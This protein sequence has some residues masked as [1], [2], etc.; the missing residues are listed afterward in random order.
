MTNQE[1]TKVKIERKYHYFKVPKNFGN[2]APSLNFL[3]KYSSNRNPIQI[4]ENVSRGIYRVDKISP[5]RVEWHSNSKLI[6]MK[7][8]KSI[9]KTKRDGDEEY[10]IGNLTL[11]KTASSKMALESI[12]NDAWKTKF[13]KPL[14]REV[15]FN[16]ERTYYTRK[17]PFPK[18]MKIFNIAR[19]DSLVKI[20]RAHV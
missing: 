20:G 6:S 4:S 5:N 12:N 2:S 11:R 17:S 10:K 8:P 19:Q 7:A 9:L 15:T 1:I 13:K 16:G 14:R 3:L 18:V